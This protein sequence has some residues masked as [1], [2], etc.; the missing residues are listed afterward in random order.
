MS[1]ATWFAIVCAV[2][3]IVA[4][5]RGWR[6]WVTIALVVLA[7]YAIADAAPG[8]AATFKGAGHKIVDVGTAAGEAG[9]RK[10]TQ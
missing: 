4:W 5:K 9:F 3:A 2:L 10:A 8:A 6:A 7:G 1:G